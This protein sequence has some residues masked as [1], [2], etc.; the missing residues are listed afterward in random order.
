[1]NL[2]I[3]IL[4]CGRIAQKAMI[5]ALNSSKVAELLMIGSRFSKKAKKYSKQFGCKYYGTYEDVLKNKDVE[6]VY[7]S[8]PIGLH[9]KWV[10]KAAEAGKHILCEKTS[11]TSFKSAKK[12]VKSCKKNNVRIMEAFMFKHHPQHKKVKE[13]IENNELGELLTFYGMYGSPFFD[14]KDMRL[15]KKLGGGALNDMG[16]YPIS[17]SRMIFNEEPK[18]VYCKFKKDTTLDDVDVKADITLNYSN[19]KV[20][21][22]SASYSAY[23]QTNYS[24][25]GTKSYLKVNRAY[26]VYSNMKTN[27]SKSIDDD[28]SEEIIIKAVDQTKLMVESFCKGIFNEK[29]QDFEK[30]LLLQAKVMDAA[31]IS[32]KEKRIVYLSEFK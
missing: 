11:T 10:I 29:N 23:Y 21:F 16:C 24:C 1:M 20:A 31:R 2:K 5:P 30:D 27:I 26:A 25:W 8:L 28:T 32:D 14:K 22:C 6:V 4:G 19:G 15:N 3:G 13:I 18:S 12:M 17:A 7:I 9:E